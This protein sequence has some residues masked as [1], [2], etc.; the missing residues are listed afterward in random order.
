MPIEISLSQK[1]EERVKKLSC[2]YEVSSAIRKHS[3]SLI[4]M[5]E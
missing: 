2:H 5:L 4:E 3:G 1:L